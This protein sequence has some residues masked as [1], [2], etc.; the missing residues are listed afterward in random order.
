MWENPTK[1]H[2]VHD[3]SERFS[4]SVSQELIMTHLLLRGT[5]LLKPV[6]PKSHGNQLLMLIT[7]QS[8]NSF[9]NHGLFKYSII[10]APGGSIGNFTTFEG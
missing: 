3:S 10:S 9:C 1:L 5:Q 6:M 7:Q 8:C 2:S 4:M